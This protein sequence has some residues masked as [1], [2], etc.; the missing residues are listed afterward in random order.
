MANTENARYLWRWQ[1]SDSIIGDQTTV[2]QRPIELLQRLIRFDTTNPPGN[3]E[4]CIKYVNQLLTA[5]G[6]ETTILAKLPNR[7]SLITRLKGKG[8]APPL[9]LYGHV[10]VQITKNQ[11]WTH[12]PFGGE[13]IDGYLWGRGALDMKGGMAMMMAALLRSKAEGL[14][15]AGDVVLALL[16]DE[17]AFGDFG[18]KYLVEEHSA[19]FSGIKYALGEIGGFT[20]HIDQ[21]RFYPIQ[22]ADT[23]IKAKG[24]KQVD[25]FGFSMGG[26]VA[27]EIVLKEPQLVRKMILAGTGPAGGEGI[28]TVAGVTFYDILRGFFTGQDAKQFLFFTR[29][30]GGIEAGKAFLERLKERAQ[31]RDKEITVSALLAQL[32]ALRT[33]GL[34]A[35]GGSVG[36]QAARAGG[37]RRRRPH[38]ADDEHPRPGAAP[39]Q[40][41]ADRLPRRRPWR[42]LPVPCRLRAQGT[43][44]PGAIEPSEGRTRHDRYPSHRPHPLR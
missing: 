35:A 7:P 3:E 18:A 10:D 8:N 34:K 37:Q 33:W 5:A 14:T 2:Y 39:A 1:I 44:V 27:Q 20:M 6:F 19:L 23:F 40:Q 29:T 17:E 16:C 11:I 26:M 28:S 41:H 13:I 31:N 25:L 43:R 32:E 12:P 4:D 22:V 30:P 42:H 21:K 15:P 38:G 9:L 36:R 24:F